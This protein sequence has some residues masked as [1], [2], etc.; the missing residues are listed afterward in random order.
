MTMGI[1]TYFIISVDDLLLGSSRILRL[2]TFFNTWN[3]TGPP[4]KHRKT[5]TPLVAFLSWLRLEAE[6]SYERALFSSNDAERQAGFWE[7]DEGGLKWKEKCDLHFFRDIFHHGFFGDLICDSYPH[8]RFFLQFLVSRNTGLRRKSTWRIITE[9]ILLL[10]LPVPQRRVPS[11]HSPPTRPNLEVKVIRVVAK[12]QA[13]LMPRKTLNLRQNLQNRAHL[14]KSLKPTRHWRVCLWSNLNLSDI[15]DIHAIST[16]SCRQSRTKSAEVFLFQRFPFY[17]RF[18]CPIAFWCLTPF[19]G[20]RE[21]GRQQQQCNGAGSCN[22]CRWPQWVTACNPPWRLRNEG[23]W[24][25]PSFPVVQEIRDKFT[26]SPVDIRYMNIWSTIIFR[27]L[28]LHHR[29]FFSGFLNHQ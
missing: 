27:V 17:V 22:K 1:K 18:R 6:R 13:T 19:W 23:L 14:L 29:W 15:A 8:L 2:W 3:S 25:L 26:H 24:T 7:K 10:L 21:C 9:T 11:P 5:P 4:W 12:A 28:F 20:Q 16:T